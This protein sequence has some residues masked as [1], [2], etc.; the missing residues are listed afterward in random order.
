M[1]KLI[2]L[3]LAGYLLG[4]VNPSYIIGRI[5]GV[6]IRQKGSGNAGGSNA[7]INFGKLIGIICI[8]LD[9]A[10][11]ALI[12]YLAK[13]LIGEP[14]G[15]AICG[16]AVIL[17]H[18]FPFYMGFKGGKG[19]ACLSGFVLAYA[20]LV[21]LIMLVFTVILVLVTDYICIAPMADSVIFAVVYGILTKS[22]IGAAVIGIAAVAI[23]FRHRE[24]IKRIRAG[25]E[26]HF[27]YLLNKDKE[28]ERISDK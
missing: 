22:I 6:D 23:F 21:F 19:F 20:P 17:G 12:V 18:M 5:K 14:V 13:W 11:S 8:I 7:V 24:N 15:V 4:S 27:S 2:I 1:L 10:K 25:N 3:A 28:M 16:T 26:L 9:I